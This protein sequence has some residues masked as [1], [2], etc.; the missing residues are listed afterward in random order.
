M[1]DLNAYYEEAFSGNK[2]EDKEILNYIK[3]YKKII[4]WGASFLGK[5][6]GEYLLKNDIKIDN[7]WDLRFSDI[8]NVNGIDVVPP[9]STDDKENTIVIFCIGNNV[10]RGQLLKNLNENGYKNVIRG[11]YLYMGAICPFTNGM[12]ID[13]SICQ[14]S[15][16]CRSM[17]CQRLASIVKNRSNT[18]NPLYTYNISLIVNQR[19]SLKCKCCTSYMN[20]YPTNKRINIPYERIA[21][22]IDKFFGAMDSV[23]TVTV[24]GGEPFM[25]P[26]LPKIVKKLLEKKN[27]GLVSVATSGTYPIKPEMLEGLKDKRVNVSFSN[28]EQSLTDKQIKVMHE[29]IE[30]VRNSGVAYTVGVTLAEWLI[31][32]TLYDLHDDEQTMIKKKQACVQPPRCMHLKNGKLH[33]CD[34]GNAL[35]SLGIADYKTDYVDLEN[36]NDIS[37]LKEKLRK[38]I[39]QPYYRT[40]GHCDFSMGLTSKPA[41]QGYMDF[42]KP[43]D[44]N[45][46]SN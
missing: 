41:E 24:M 34:F 4:L 20:E 13:S 9:F 19:C 18:Q 15:M 6:V 30:T 10:I 33:P 31:P 11:D 7:Y 43:L 39:D 8:K 44:L 14:G 17:F 45:K 2:V 23:G 26:D 28:Y 37:D 12:E 46:K 3:G 40:C 29:S 38:F 1:F 21:D 16:C 36:S 5:A 27:F 32:S 35:Y 42:T 22:D 25:H